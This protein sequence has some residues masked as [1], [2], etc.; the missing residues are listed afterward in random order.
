MQIIH[1]APLAALGLGAAFT[2]IWGVADPVAALAEVRIIEA[3]GYYIMGDG[4]EENA[5]VAKERARADARRAAS[6]QA[7]LYVAGMTEVKKGKLTR[8]EIRTIS[9]AV[10][11]VREDD[12]TPEVLGGTVIQYH[13]HMKAVVDTG[14]ITDQLRQDKVKLDEAVRRNQELEKQLAAV[15]EELAKIKADYK[16]ANDAERA[17][18]N[19]EMKVNEQKFEAIEW[20][21]KG[22]DLYRKQQYSEAVTAF[23]NALDLNPDF[24]EAWNNI[25][26]VYG[27]Q[28]NTEEWLR[29]LNKAIHLDPSNGYAFNNLGI[30][31]YNRGEYQK[32]LEC[33]QKSTKLEPKMAIAWNNLG[34]AHYHVGDISAALE[35]FQKSVSLDSK[36]ASAWNNMGMIY[37]AQ[38][39]F[40]KSIECYR[41]SLELDPQKDNTWR[42]LACAYQSMGNYD[43]AVE[44]CQQA[45]KINPENASAWNSLGA[46]YYEMERY[47]DAVHAFEKAIEINPKDKTYQANRDAAKSML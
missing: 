39:K 35:N 46:I 2:V 21:Q 3:D 22:M 41:K 38:G 13:C 18:L 20:N 27:D 24:A 29:A 32:A 23:R 15:N 44:C 9:A 7:G 31:H 43:K 6:E 25:G 14:S 36:N 19:D 30:Y 5:A 42:N 17:R 37:Q 11:E 1:Q 33:F 45:L 8:D 34:N 40:S 47:S 4:P 12:V 16:N 26:Q 28:G 10:L